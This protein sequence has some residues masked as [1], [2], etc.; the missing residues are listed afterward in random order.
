MKTLAQ[1]VLVLGID[2]LDPKLTKKYIDEGIMPN[3]QK[4]MDKGAC[5][6]DLKM[7]GGQPTVTPPMW[8]T[9]ATGAHPCT[10]GIT[11]YYA[12]TQERLDVLLYNFDSTRCKAEPLW[13]V[14]AEA[15][16]KTLVWHWP[17]SSWPPTS[18][19]PNLAVV[20]GTQPAGP[21]AGVAEVDAEKLVV[22]SEKT[23]EVKYAQKAASDSK[24][25]CFMPGMEIE[26]SLEATSY[27]KVHAQEVTGIAITPEE[28][29]HNLSDTP[30]DICFSPIR[31]AAGWENAP[32]GAKEFTLLHSAG[33]LRRVGLIL[34]NP[35]GCYD[36]VEIYKNKKSSE[37][38]A[39]AY[40]DEFVHDVLD[41][42]Y[43]NDDKII[44]NRNMRVLEIAEDGSALKM[45]VSAGMDH[46][47][48]TLWHPKELL[49]DIVEHVGYP[50]PVCTTAGS[51]ERLITKCV[52]ANW[53]AAAQWNAAA[54]KY[55]AE[56]RGYEIIFSHFH[57]VDLQGHLLVKFLA[58]GSSK[59]APE[60]YQRLFR[61]VY[62]QT[63]QYIGEFLELLDKGWTIL[64]VSDHGQICP[65]HGRTDFLVGTNAINAVY[66]KKWGYLTLKQDAN[67][68]DLH[69]IDWSKTLA[70]P[71][72]MNQV[73]INLKGRN[74]QGIVDPSDK[75]ELEERIMTDMYKLT[76]PK[77][78]HRLISLALRNED[79]VLLGVGGPE[80]GDI[81]YFIAQGYNDD[82]ADSLS[83][84][85][86]TCD[87]SVASIFMAAGAGIKTNYRT[88]RLVKHV[89]VTPTVAVLAGLRMPAQC[90]GAPVYQILEMDH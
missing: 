28:S 71:V 52:N 45:W 88:E 44:V 62:K 18:D 90:E 27:D 49:A 76:H 67:G 19:S 22:A 9:L 51:D 24:I 74:P 78:G 81:I 48:D 47:N 40:V 70:A 59:L 86:G 75:F 16:R 11:E 14:A 50:Q 55:L 82:H 73:Y 43:H 17:G 69:E 68:E 34:K 38:L 36:H 84:M 10:H 3:T 25:P 85:Y 46:T 79:A 4:F 66:F 21:N 61:D 80:S 53:T 63:D 31:S 7:I 56:V 30:F 57:N 20:D 12:N 89:D 77:T 29:F 60:V 87:T 8:T 33:K 83:T 37:P 54:I 6:E 35:E 2:G 41:E 5:R 26:E 32:A 65:E 72:R 13:N 42:A 1:K 39:V 23:P 58:E 64:I 15:G